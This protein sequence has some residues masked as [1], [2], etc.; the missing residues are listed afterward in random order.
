MLYRGAAKRLEELYRANP[1][2]HAEVLEEEEDYLGDL[3]EWADRNGIL[4]GRIDKTMKTPNLRYKYDAKDKNVL[5]I[6]VSGITPY[7]ATRIRRA[8]VSAVPVMAIDDIWVL[9]NDSIYHEDM[10]R[11]RLK[12]I[13]LMLDPN[14]YDDLPID[15]KS[16]PEAK[17]QYY[18]DDNA[19]AFL[20]DTRNIERSDA[21]SRKLRTF[22]ASDLQTIPVSTAVSYLEGKSNLDTVVEQ[23]EAVGESLFGGIELFKLSPTQAFSAILFGYRGTASQ[24]ANFAALSDFTYRYVTKVTLTKPIQGQDAIALKK[25]CPFGVYD[26]EDTGKAFVADT[27]RCTLCTRCLRDPRF[28]DSVATERDTSRFIFKLESIGALESKSIFDEALRIAIRDESQRGET[29][30][31][32]V[33]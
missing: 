10:L 4:D 19:V 14:Q 13:P 24:R 32:Y 23:A 16:S 30:K 15:R 12:L 21:T 2:Y 11:D 26:V 31:S 33:L 27:T 17:V 22:Y 1:E 3:R 8:A 28:S 6:E 29:M 18:T 7:F 5:S 9:L 25:L 20:L